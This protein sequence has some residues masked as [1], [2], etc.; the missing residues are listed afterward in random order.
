MK[1]LIQNRR[2][3]KIRILLVSFRIQKG[4]QPTV[5]RSEK[6]F[7]I[8]PIL[9]VLKQISEDGPST[10]Q[11]LY[12]NSAEYFDRCGGSSG[13]GGTAG[14]LGRHAGTD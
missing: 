10:A 11:A 9:H 1:F 14:L 7:Q 3:Q 12:F 8:S 4:F 6:I 13:G 5:L 2:H